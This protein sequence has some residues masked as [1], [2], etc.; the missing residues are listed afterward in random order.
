[1]VLPG[2]YIAHPRLKVNG[3]WDVPALVGHG[4]LTLGCFTVLHGNAHLTKLIEAASVHASFF[5]QEQRVGFA[6]GRHHDLV[7]GQFLDHLR[8]LDDMVL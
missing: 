4:G 1:M 3:D 2:R 8:C 5:G 7:L 6:A